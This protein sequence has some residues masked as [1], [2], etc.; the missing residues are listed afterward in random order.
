[1]DI[2]LRIE[3]LERYPNL[4]RKANKGIKTLLRTLAIPSSKK[5]IFMKS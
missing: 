2:M 1:M 4:K 5:H 3:I